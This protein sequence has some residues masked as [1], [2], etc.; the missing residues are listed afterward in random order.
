MKKSKVKKVAFRLKA[1]CGDHVEDN[2][3]YVAGDKVMSN[4]NLEKLFKNKFERIHPEDDFDF[5]KAGP[6]IPSPR[7]VLDKDKGEEDQKSSSSKSGK[8]K[9]STK[10]GRNITLSFP[11]AIAAELSVYEKDHWCQVVDRNTED[12]KPEVVSEKKLREKEVDSFLETF[13][14]SENEDEDEDDDDEDEDE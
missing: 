3:T 11:K 7:T 1:R 12:G 5:A 14:E 9:N 6:N 10:F 4:R 8:Y 2:V 13:V